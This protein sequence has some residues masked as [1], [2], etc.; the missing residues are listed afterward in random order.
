MRDIHRRIK[1]NKA[2]EPGFYRHFRGKVYYAF[3]TAE[4]SETG[5]TMV[6]YRAQ[7][8]DYKLFVRPLAMFKETID[9][10]GYRGPRFMLV[11]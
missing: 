2:I 8:G 3:G 4:H 10:N 1:K 7:Y 9:R 6:I 11:K 5:E